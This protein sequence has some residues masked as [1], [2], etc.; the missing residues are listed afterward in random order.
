MPRMSTEERKREIG[1]Q[2]T[3]CNIVDALYASIDNLSSRRL[4][5]SS[6]TINSSKYSIGC[7]AVA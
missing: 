4:I 5:M 6:F 3:G 1:M 7:T 2:Q